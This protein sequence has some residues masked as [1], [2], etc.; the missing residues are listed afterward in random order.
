MILRRFISVLLL[1]S[2]QR[3]LIYS[4]M[5]PRAE[6]LNHAILVQH[7][8][9]GSQHER[10]TRK[11]ENQW[12]AKNKRSTYVDAVAKIDQLV[13]N[14]LSGIRDIISGHR[15][16]LPAHHDTVRQADA[17]LTEIFPFGVYA[18]TS[19]PYVD[20]V[21]A[22]EVLVD[23][24][25][26]ELAPLVEHFGLQSK[27]A[28]LAE[29]VAEY[30]RLVDLGREDVEFTQVRKSRN[31]GQQI[32]REVVAIVLGTYFD[33]Q[34][35]DHVAARE[36]LL[37]PLIEELDAQHSRLR[38]QRRTKNGEPDGDTEIEAEIELDDDTEIEPEIELDSQ[39]EIEPDGDSGSEAAA[40]S[41]SAGDKRADND[42]GP[43]GQ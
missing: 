25:Q 7:I 28:Q 35:D 27:L 14:L 24:M 43:L 40:L 19:L 16:G 20:E 12:S 38:V 42:T 21:M 33:S 30:R 31:R 8:A 17:F 22:V 37:E 18:I 26:G 3:F 15:K 34:D 11:L 9:R 36:H 6:A 5:R 2:G 10:A 1:S 4:R 13:D 39:T 29:L 23:K 32:L 41:G